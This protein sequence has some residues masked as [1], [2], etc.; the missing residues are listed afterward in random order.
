MVGILSSDFGVRH[1]MFGPAIPDKG[2]APGPQIQ[3]RLLPY[4]ESARQIISPGQAGLFGSS[5]FI[6]Q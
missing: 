6:V 1:P 4:V 3:P 2:Q 5:F